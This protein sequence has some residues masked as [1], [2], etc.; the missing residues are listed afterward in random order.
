MT[1]FLYGYGALPE[2]V[3]A[4]TVCHTGL[5]ATCRHRVT[6]SIDIDGREGKKE[7]SRAKSP[8]VSIAYTLR[9]IHTYETYQALEAV[10]KTFQIRQL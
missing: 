10:H 1:Q 6:S 4:G 8:A 5:R 2:R 9:I 7:Y 3:H